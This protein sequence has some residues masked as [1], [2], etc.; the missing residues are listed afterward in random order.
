MIEIVKTRKQQLE[1]RIKRLESYV[2]E[3][4]NT[5]QLKKI[6]EDQIQFLREELKE[7]KN[8]N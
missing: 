1:E 4:D 8:K 6:Y 3:D 7:L 5:P 2:Y